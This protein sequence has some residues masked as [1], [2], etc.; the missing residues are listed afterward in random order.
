M[1]RLLA[2]RVTGVDWG[3]VANRVLRKHSVAKREEVR[4]ER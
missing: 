3:C 1:T 2:E 4:V